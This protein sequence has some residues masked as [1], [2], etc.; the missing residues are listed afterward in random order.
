MLRIDGPVTIPRTTLPL[1]VPARLCSAGH[2]PQATVSGVDS[3]EHDVDLAIRVIRLHCATMRWP[4]SQR[5]LNCGWPYPCVTHRW[6]RQVLAAAGWT[7]DDI[8]G[9]DRRTGPWS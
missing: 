8:A 3:N 4:D 5:C 1:D 9:L 7:D 6:G 2:Q